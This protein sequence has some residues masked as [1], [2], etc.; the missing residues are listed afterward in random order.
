M[1]Q[2]FA[3]DRGAVVA[4]QA[5]LRARG[6]F[7]VLA[8]MACVLGMA[9]FVAACSDDESSGSKSEQTPEDVKA[10]M[11]EVLDKLPTMVDLG[12]EA[13][14][15][16]SDG[17]FDTATEKFDELHEVWEEVEGT[18]KD[19]DADTYEQI[20]TAQGLIR[21]GAETEKADRVATGADDQAAAVQQFI[22][23]NQ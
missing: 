15:A 10:P 21:D 16:A 8:V 23:D 17:D 20:E 1:E 22:A 11:S 6:G 4:V 13:S 9:T 5:N 12:N 14:T 7:R 19:T 3:T 2:S 18:V